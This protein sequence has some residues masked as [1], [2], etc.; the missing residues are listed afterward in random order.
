MVFR[1]LLSCDYT[2]REDPVGLVWLDYGVT[3]L[4][5][6]AIGI[7]YIGEIVKKVLL[8]WPDFF[9]A[10]RT[11]LF[12]QNVLYTPLVLGLGGHM[13]RFLTFILSP[14]SN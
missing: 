4:S 14:P 11:W 9:F 10:E 12:R 8:L 6:K 7:C 2:A 1:H 13:T 5:V 3:R